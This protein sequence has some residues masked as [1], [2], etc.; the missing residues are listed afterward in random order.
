VVDD[1]S[2]VR[3][4]LGRLLRQAGYRVGA[5]ASGE[6]FLASLAGQRPDCAVVDV[7][8][9]GLS[10]FEL[11]ARLR[12]E[13]LPIPVILITASDDLTLDLSALDAGALALA[14]QALLQRRAAGGDCQCTGGR[15][16]GA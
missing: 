9:P 3:V 6:D 7:Q 13:T 11:Q 5:F 2:P 12:S 8:L 16:D 15:H 14:A 4:M 1:E 10:G